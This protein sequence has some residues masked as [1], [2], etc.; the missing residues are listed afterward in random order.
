MVDRALNQWNKINIVVNNAYSGGIRGDAVRRGRDLGSGHGRRPEVDVPSR[1]VR[2]PAYASRRR[3]LDD[4]HLLGPRFTRRT[5]W[6]VYE[7][8]KPAVIG[9]TRQLA[10]EYGPD[11]IRVNAICPGHIVT[12]RGEKQWHEHPEG[13]RFFE[14][15]YPLRRTGKPWISPMRSCSCAR[16]KRRSSP[17]KP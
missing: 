15:Q 2:G 1:Q 8:V 3:R 6:F 17:A 10:S 4:Q 12:E 7:V 11:N 14:Q 5:G 13:L 16:T 9:L